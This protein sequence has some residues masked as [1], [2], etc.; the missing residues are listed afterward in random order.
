MKSKKIA[1]ITGASGNLG[2]AVVKKF[3]S[4]GYDVIGI[5]HKKSSLPDTLKEYYSEFEL[6]L[7]DQEVCEQT[8]Q[9][10]I[11]NKGSID[12]AVLTAGGFAMGSIMHSKASDIYTQYQ[13]NFE[14]AYNIARPVFTQMIQQN[15][16][17]IF[18]I[19]SRPGFDVAQGKGLTAY[20]LTKSLLYRLSELLN[21][22]ANEKNIVSS[23]ITISTIDTPQNRKSMPK[24]N[25]ATWVKPEEIAEIISFYASEQAAAIREPVIKIYNQS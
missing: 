7:R 16:G 18:F 4:S 8:I 12:V 20:A 1:L 23:V 2:Q 13:L 24:A 6:D 10:I 15:Y 11:E 22:E 17:R 19:G 25:F 14:T 5:V 21:A 3:I 9:N